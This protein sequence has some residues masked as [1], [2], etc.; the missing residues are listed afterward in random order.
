MLM[1]LP[2]HSNIYQWWYCGEISYP[3]TM[4]LIKASISI[5]LL[6]IC[7]KRY[8]KIIIW[9][10]LF[11]TIV[12]SLVLILTLAFQCSPPSYFWTKYLGEPGSCLAGF[13]IS[14]LTYSHGALSILT[15]WTLGILP[16]FL[17]W[18]LNMNPRTKVSVAFILGLGAL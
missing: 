3:T 4:C 14:S 13:T 1:L 2:R 11:A 18:N 6:Q 16:I 15:D 17:V 9:T 5:F 10:V 12:Y 7:V 8:Q